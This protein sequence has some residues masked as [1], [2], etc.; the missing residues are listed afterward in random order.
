MESDAVYGIFHRHSPPKSRITSSK[1]SS[2]VII[3]SSMKYISVPFRHGATMMIIAGLIATFLVILS[4]VISFSASHFIPSPHNQPDAEYNRHNESPCNKSEH[5]IAD[6]VRQI[7]RTSAFVATHDFTDNLP[8]DY[9]EE[10]RH[11]TRYDYQ[12]PQCLIEAHSICTSLSIPCID[13]SS[14]RF[15][16]CV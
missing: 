3:P 5:Q 2:T 13:V 6:E 10:H 1:D 16:L 15:V 8:A 9:E 4:Y 11:Q 7:C 14:F 12:Y